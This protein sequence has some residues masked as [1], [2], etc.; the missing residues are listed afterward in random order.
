MQI[1]LTLS[2]H[3]LH[4]TPLARRGSPKRS[5]NIFLATGLRLLILDPFDSQLH[6][7]PPAIRGSLLDINVVRN[8]RNSS[9]T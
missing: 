7:P 1:P 8:E 9:F 4:L 2:H 6:V 5:P 3:L